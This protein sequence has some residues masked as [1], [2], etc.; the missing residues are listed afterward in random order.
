MD[1][2]T[3]LEWFRFADT[4]LGAANHMLSMRPQPLEII[5]YHCQQSAEKYLKGY[6][7]YKGVIE[8]PK[9]HNLVT[10]CN[11][12]A[13]YDNHFAEIRKQCV[14]LSDYGIQPRYPHELFI[15]EHHMTKALDYARQIK[16]FAPIMEA[17]QNLEG[18][19]GDENE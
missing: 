13:T 8:P 14:V 3:I 9:T 17:R 5:C 18:V 15:E 2:N 7:I 6:L 11:L 4:D 10:L 16:T 1:N 19:T 12:C